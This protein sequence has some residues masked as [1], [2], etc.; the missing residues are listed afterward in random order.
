MGN[1]RAAQSG[2]GGKT[3]KNRYKK[4]IK[5]LAKDAPYYISMKDN[6]VYICSMYYVIKISPIDYT[7]YFQS[8]AGIFPDI[9]NGQSYKITPKSSTPVEPWESD[10]LF[11]CFDMVTTPGINTKLLRI[12]EMNG[13]TYNIIASQIALVYL[14]NAYFD[15]IMAIF[16]GEDYKLLANKD[17]EPVIIKSVFAE[18]MILPFRMSDDLNEPL[19]EAFKPYSVRQ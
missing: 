12:S 17:N 8:E 7:N 19:L 6:K 14:N 1:K 11:K 10:Y 4:F 16:K 2:I 13:K 15:S 3:V 9:E 5:Q 18:A